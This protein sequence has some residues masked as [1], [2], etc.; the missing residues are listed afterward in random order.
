MNTNDDLVYISYTLSD[1]FK[2]HLNN[3]LI[4]LITGTIFLMWIIKYFFL[5]RNSHWKIEEI[6]VPLGTS[7]IK[8]KRTSE[9]SR[10]AHVAWAEIVTRK[11][12]LP[13]DEKHD[14][15]VEVYNSWYELFKKIR[16][17][18][19]TIPVEELSDDGDAKKL[20]KVLISLLNDTLRPHLTEWQ[21]KFRVWFEHKR[22]KSP[23]LS[24]QII[25][26]QY[27]DFHHLIGDLKKVNNKVIDLSVALKKL[28]H[29]ADK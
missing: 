9:V 14:L 2:F 26:R 28:A 8:L 16:E 12:A 27:K 6:E 22:S 17:L 3:S 20:L 25:Q 29:G 19:V 7:K 18:I 23:G 11:A 24:P 13:F 15:I 5:N 10:I 21:A 1:G 4:F